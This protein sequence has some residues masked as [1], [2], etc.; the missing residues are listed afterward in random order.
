MTSSQGQVTLVYTPIEAP[1]VEYSV[2]G[3]SVD[4]VAARLFD[5]WSL[6]GD[7]V[8]QPFEQDGTTFRNVTQVFAQALNNMFD[9][10]DAA[11]EESGRIVIRGR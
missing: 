7:I 9:D 11:W 3:G 10:I 4:D 8:V 2:E 1:E 6:H 5:A